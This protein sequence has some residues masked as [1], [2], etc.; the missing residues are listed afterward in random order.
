MALSISGALL[1]LELLLAEISMA[2]K[3]F[4]LCNGFLTIYTPEANAVNKRVQPKRYAA[5]LTLKTGFSGSPLNRSSL[6][7][8][9]SYEPMTV[10]FVKNADLGSI[11][12]SSLSILSAAFGSIASIT[13]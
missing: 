3:Q 6:S 10:S 7:I 11:L 2:K 13:K 1:D 12:V 5:S 9:P 4:F 8:L